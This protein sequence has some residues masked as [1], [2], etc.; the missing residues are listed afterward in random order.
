MTS[1]MFSVV[2]PT[3]NRETEVVHAVLSAVNFFHGTGF[4]IL[5][6]DDGSS[7][8]TI[9]QLTARFDILINERK[10]KILQNSKN[11]GVNVSRSIGIE[12]A[13]APYVV[14]LDSDDELI[15]SNKQEFFREIAEHPSAPLL[16]F[17]CV[18]QD[19]ENIG[20]RLDET[21]RVT[22]REYVECS[23]SGEVL[24]VV[25]KDLVKTVPYDFDLVGCEGLAYTRVIERHGAAINSKYIVR[26][27]NQAG[28]ERLSSPKQFVNRMDDVAKFHLRM[29]REFSYCMSAT[30]ILKL[31]TKVMVFKLIYRFRRFF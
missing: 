15:G 29:L 23:S 26:L 3:Y 4:E 13:R 1:V 6:V 25:N 11:R 18:N 31:I 7:D 2:I 24:I 21:Y 10:I 17:R 19:G 27:Y 22:L 12:A 9:D 30:R 16:F 28:D 20:K 8:G 5:I 14:L